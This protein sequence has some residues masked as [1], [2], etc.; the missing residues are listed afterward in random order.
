MARSSQRGRGP[1]ITPWT[2]VNLAEH[3][4]DDWHEYP[5]N[6]QL[7]AWAQE[8]CNAVAAPADIAEEQWMLTGRLALAVGEDLVWSSLVLQRVAAEAGLRYAEVGAEQVEALTTLEPLS[9]HAPVLLHLRGGSWMEEPAADAPADVA[10][11]RLALHERLDAMLEAFVPA[12]PVVVVVTVRAIPDIAERFRRL[13]RFDRFIRVAP[14]PREEYGRIFIHAV[15]E[16]RCGRSLTEA[17]ERVGELIML[18][19]EEQR[20]RG[21]AAIWLTRLSAREQ[22]PV[23]FRDLVQLC[24]LGF[25]EGSSVHP[26]SEAEL[27]A[28]AVHEAGHVVMAICDSAGTNIPEYASVIG[29]AENAGE[30]MVSLEFLRRLREKDTFADLRH[31]VRVTLGG[32][33]AEELLLGVE[34]VTGGCRGDI[35]QASRAC[36]RAFGQLGFSPDMLNPSESGNSLLQCVNDDGDYVSVSAAAHVEGLARRFLADEYR[37]VRTL[38]DHQR[39]FLEAVAKA[40]MAES[41]LVQEQLRQLA[42][43]HVVRP[44]AAEKEA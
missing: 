10:A 36:R 32:R 1:G 38:L 7:Q 12:N 26:P 34:S 21:L 44:G 4:S 40:L 23:E 43:E 9:A 33:G 31:H 35:E 15:G 37:A 13:H 27:W 22:R 41:F 18:Y 3:S 11:N 5:G 6:E 42:S 17:P 2:F 14:L 20:R 19:F 16:E 25:G 24:S 30:M 39:G 28:T 29:N 8:L